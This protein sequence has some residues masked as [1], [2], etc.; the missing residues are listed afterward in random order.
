MKLICV[1]G[2]IGVGKTTVA[3][4]LVN[5]IGDANSLLEDFSLHPFL[6]DFYADPKYTFETEINFLLIHYHQLVK[7]MGEQHILLISD[8]CFLK[9]K[10]F[11]DANI[12]SKK[13]L[14]IFMRL[15]SYLQSRLVQPDAIICLSGTTDMIYNRIIKRN[16]KAEKSISYDYVD[17]INKHYELF[18]S[19]LKK[20]HYTI[21]VNMNENDFINDPGLI[22]VIKR[23]LEEDVVLSCN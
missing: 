5:I 1:E 3:T 2:C 12:L 13:E 21:N 17:K 20:S 19:E 10:L 9:D 4:Q 6:E 18:F 14:D 7:A 15:Y 8:Y 16:R 23:K 22:Y 11:A